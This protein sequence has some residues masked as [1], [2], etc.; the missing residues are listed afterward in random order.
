MSKP[1][2]DTAGR[3]WYDYE[4]QY[5]GPDG[6][7]GFVIKAV[8]EDHARLMLDDIKAS[9]EVKGRIVSTHRS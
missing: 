7:F 5:K 9:G 2:V 3:V 8:S 4:V 1:Y 6:T